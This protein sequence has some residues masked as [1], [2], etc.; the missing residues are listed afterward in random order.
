MALKTPK[1]LDVNF[2]LGG[3][4]FT[5]NNAEMFQQQ[6]LVMRIFDIIALSFGKMLGKASEYV[7]LAGT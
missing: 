6:Q 4:H 2:Y 5:E 1:Q 7:A 3:S